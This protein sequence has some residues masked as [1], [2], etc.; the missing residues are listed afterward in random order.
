MISE[1]RDLLTHS[2]LEPV[3]L[4]PFQRILLVADG[5]L[6]KILEAHLTEALEVVKLSEEVITITQ[7]ILPLE[8]KTG[9]EVIKRNILLQ[10]QITQRNWLYAE[11][12]IVLERLDKEFREELIESDIPIGKLWLEH[13]IETFKEI[14]TSAREPANDLS[15]YFNVS[16]EEKVL[17]RTYR[18]FSKQQP[19]MMITEKFPESYFL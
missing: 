8:I 19:V 4:T 17:Y 12:I 7:D 16:R 10:G 6:T 11:S 18:V 5:T 9:C 13:K 3:E 14:I 2:Q 15:E 1:W